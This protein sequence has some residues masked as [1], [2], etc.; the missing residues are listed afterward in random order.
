[1]VGGDMDLKTKSEESQQTKAEKS[2]HKRCFITFS[3]VLIGILKVYC[4][5]LS[6]L[7]FGMIPNDTTGIIKLGHCY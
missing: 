5:S 7:F 4:C 6:L 3:G 1:M 2:R